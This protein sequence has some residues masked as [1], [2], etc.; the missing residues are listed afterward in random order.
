MAAAALRPC[1]R[2][3]S[4]GGSACVARL[5]LH[6]HTTQT[7]HRPGPAVQV[8]RARGWRGLG[9]AESA[10]EEFFPHHGPVFTAQLVALG[11]GPFALQAAHH[12][13]L[14][15]LGIPEPAG[16]LDPGA[17]LL[18]CCRWRGG[19]GRWWLAGRTGSCTIRP[20]AP[21]TTADAAQQQDSQ[22]RC[23]S[24]HSRSPLSR[25]H[26][27]A[28]SCSHCAQ[29]TGA[30]ASVA[31]DLPWLA[32]HCDS[33]GLP[34]ASASAPAWPRFF[35][36]QAPG[37]SSFVVQGVPSPNKKPGLGGRVDGLD[38]QVLGV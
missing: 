21:L 22:Q 25:F 16:A 6:I 7:P 17:G 30:M 33:V 24:R 10:F 12:R 27:R 13:L 14:A 5:S 28:L 36:L 8:A 3:R 23:C 37:R 34:M 1:A 29:P 18:R 15:P 11:Q 9:I 32:L 26:A 2:R 19:L 38:G 4:A 31:C 35:V 20:R